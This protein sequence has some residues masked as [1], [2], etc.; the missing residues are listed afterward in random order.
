MASEGD[1]L[2]ATTTDHADAPS[3]APESPERFGIL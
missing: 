2:T 1:M 3:L